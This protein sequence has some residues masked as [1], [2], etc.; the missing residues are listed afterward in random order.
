MRRSVSGKIMVDKARFL[1][2]CINRDA[3]E[4]PLNPKCKLPEEE[5][6]DI[7]N[8]PNNEELRRAV[9]TLKSNN[10][11]DSDNIPE[12]PPKYGS[13]HL[14]SSLHQLIRKIWKTEKMPRE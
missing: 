1:S 9:K 3:Q 12:E 6:E 14:I 2:C 4:A 10:A 13:E 5:E 7:N 8:L 11:L